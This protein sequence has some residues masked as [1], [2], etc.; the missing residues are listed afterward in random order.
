MCD[1]PAHH[2]DGD[3]AREAV[4]RVAPRPVEGEAWNPVALEPIDS[5]ENMRRLDLDP[6]SIEAVV[7]SHGH[8][9][10]TAGFVGLADV[11]G[12]GLVV[13]TGCGHAGVVNITR[14]AQRLASRSPRERC[15]AEIAVRG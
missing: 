2:H 15:R 6:G 5:I 14:Y 9:D 11:R 4:A 12:K 3:S 10:H 1:D 8:F 7:C 13:L